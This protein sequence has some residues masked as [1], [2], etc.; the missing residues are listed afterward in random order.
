MLTKCFMWAIAP[1]V[2][3]CPLYIWIVFSVLCKRLLR[4][5]SHLGVRIVI[6]LFGIVCLLVTDIIGHTMN[7]SKSDNHT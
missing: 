4:L 6:C 7:I 1:I 2:L 3:L 5:F